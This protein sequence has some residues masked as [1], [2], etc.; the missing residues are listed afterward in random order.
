MWIWQ[1]ANWPNFQYDTKK[2]L[3]VLED[4]IRVISPLTTLAG[5]LDTYKKLE[6]ESKFLLEEALATANGLYGS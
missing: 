6:L 1:K 5:E 4:T 3:P 2:V